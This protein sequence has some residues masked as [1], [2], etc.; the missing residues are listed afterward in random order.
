MAAAHH[1]EDETD[2]EPD[3]EAAPAGAGLLGSGRP[4]QAGMGPYAR[5]VRDGAGLCSPGRWPP[6]RR[7]PTSS[8]TIRALGAA[9]RREISRLEDT[10]GAGADDIFDR[11]AKGGYSTTPF[12]AGST[13]ALRG[14]AEQL[15]AEEGQP[16]V[17]LPRP[18]DRP[19]P[20]R[21]RLLEAL[22]R[23]GGDPD[24]NC[25]TQF[26]QGVPTGV[27]DRLP[28][29]PAVYEKKTKWRLKDQEDPELWTTPVEPHPWRD[30]YASV[31][32]HRQEVRR[33]LD[34]LVEAG[35]H[36]KMTPEDYRARWPQGTVAS[37]GAVTSEKDNGEVAVRL[38]FDG[39]HGVDV[40]RRIRVRDQE[41]PPSALDAKAFLRAQSKRR[42]PT[43]GLAADAKSAHRTIMVAEKDWGF[44][45]ARAEGDEHVYVAT[46]GTFGVSS[47]SY[48][49]NRLA[50]A[51]VRLGHYL[52]QAD[53]ELWLLLLADDFKIESSA[54]RPKR[55]VVSFLWLLD[56]LG[57]AVQWRKVQGGDCIAWVGYE[58]W[59]A[60]YALGVS[61]RRAQ[62]AV[63]FCNRVVRDGVIRVG[64]LREGLGRLAYIAGALDYD[65]PFLAPVFTFVSLFSPLAVRP[66]PLYVSTCLTYFAQ[67]VAR[68][69]HF[70]M[71]VSRTQIRDGPRV[72]AFAQGDQIGI[73]GWLPARASSGEIRKEASRWF[74]VALDANTAPWA[75][76]RGGQPYRAIAAL[77][78]YG[79]L[80]AILAFGPH[81]PADAKAK[82]R[83]QGLTDNSS[84]TFSV[85][86]LMTTKFPL[87]AIVMEIAAQS[88]SRNLIADLEWA[89]RESNEEADALS[90]GITN[91]FNPLYRIDL[92]I[93]RLPLLIL[94]RMLELGRELQELKATRRAAEHPPGGRRRAAPA[95]K[96]GLKERDPW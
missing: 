60:E 30:N 41:R 28:R 77:E 38:V 78:A 86:R 92:D 88:E 40:N 70:S 72:D 45:A 50:S 10:T 16:G 52:T 14:Y 54:Q 8:W 18:G 59:L 57:I 73:G 17:C 24:V 84:N 3:E 29:T 94:P 66:L 96:G 35:L 55:T 47:I 1:A 83:L 12:P 65:R 9:F 64:E 81:L 76:S 2:T 68:R 62:W 37:L 90:R 6:E 7:S 71:A 85:T 31:R 74:S 32:P 44:Q 75:Y 25:W 91:G 80:L 43:M 82:V 27:S 15:L 95:R 87:L 5:D 93:P 89:P 23:S 42:R 39:T 22:L 51:V 26:A 69:R 61:E 63:T 20:I 11:L 49:W 48:W 19:Q 67:R 13:E 4:L 58:F 46:C 34:E 33:Q 21:V 36:L 56:F 79:V 53:D